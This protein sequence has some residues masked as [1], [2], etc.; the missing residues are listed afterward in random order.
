M[1]SLTSLAEEILI[2]AKRLDEHLAAQKQPSPSFDH[3]AWINLSPQLESARNALIDSTH[4]LKQLTQGP[5]RATADILFN[6]DSWIYAS[7]IP[8]KL[9]RFSG[10]I[11]SPFGLSTPTS[12]L[13]LCPLMDARL[14]KK[15]PLRA[16]S[17]NQ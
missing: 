14:I 4:T 9:M 11:F 7:R 16:V 2:N 6:V 8:F 3:D 10:P 13:T 12:S 15:S 17:P 1:P 5:V